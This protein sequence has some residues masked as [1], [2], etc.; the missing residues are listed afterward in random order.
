VREDLSMDVDA[1]RPPVEGPPGE[2]SAPPRGWRARVRRTPGGAL[3]LKCA[4]FGL[5]LLFVLLGLL[6]AALPGPLTIPP[7]LLGVWIWSSEFGWAERLLE[8]ARTAAREAWAQAR[9]RPVLSAFTT[10]VGLVALGV[11]IYL[12]GRYELVD[13]AREAV[14]L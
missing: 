10:L 7:I 11:G 14:G 13:R 9:R 3:F 1:A 4:V 12:V 6:L 5:G 8:R 2:G